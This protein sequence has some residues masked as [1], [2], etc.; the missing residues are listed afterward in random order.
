MESILTKVRRFKNGL[1]RLQSDFLLSLHIQ[2]AELTRMHLQRRIRRDYEKRRR[3]LRLHER[4]GIH[5]VNSRGRELA[6]LPSD[7]YSLPMPDL[8]D[9]NDGS[10][11]PPPGS[12]LS[13][14]RPQEHLRQLSRDLRVTLPTVAAFVLVPFDKLVRAAG[15]RFLGQLSEECARP[16]ADSGEW[17]EEWRGTHWR[18][19]EEQHTTALGTAT[20]LQ[21]DAAGPVF[22]EES[23]HTLHNLLQQSNGSDGQTSI[24]DLQPTHLHSL[25]LA[26]NLS[27]PLLLPSNVAPLFL[28]TCLP[29][30]YLR[31]KLTTLAED[32]IMDDSSLIEKNQLENGCGGMTEEEVLDACWL[33][34]L[35]VGRFAIADAGSHSS[36]DEMRK[37]LT[38]HLQ[39]MEAVTT[40]SRSKMVRDATLQLLVLHLPAIRRSL[41]PKE[42]ML[43]SKRQSV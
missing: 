14:R 8:R 21:M 3:R 20:Y 43:A 9:E 39:M 27:A 42:P 31:Q 24:N 12:Y 33:R 7:V 22:S 35:P 29:N 36:L 25:A 6:F 5:V 38:H 4:H 17:T 41:T 30:A 19:A 28:Q 10:N 23:L 11:L 40:Q 37:I 13:A 16:G 1:A 26:N 34:G 15:N 2:E 18:N 32:I